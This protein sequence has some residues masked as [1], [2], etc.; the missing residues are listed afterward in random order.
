MIKTICSVLVAGAVMAGA[1]EVSPG[2][3]NL[4]GK[5][6]GER[7]NSEGKR[8][9]STF[10]IKGDQLTFRALD[11]DGQLRLLAKG[12]VKAEKVG[13]LRVLTI[14][15]LKAGRSED[16]LQPV[17]DERSSA[18]TLYEG[19]LYLA[20]GFDKPRENERPRV[21]EYTRDESAS[22]SSSDSSD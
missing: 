2:L 14:S 7:T 9:S 12:T 1:A 17:D 16:D 13:T 8:T 19:K 4:Q 15:E 6:K 20:S 21:D 3:K 18:Y 5:W 22:K 11:A 10:E